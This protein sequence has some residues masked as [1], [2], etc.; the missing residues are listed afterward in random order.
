M[1]ELRRLALAAAA[2]IPLSLVSVGIASA[3]SYGGPGTAGSSETSAT[4][5]GIGGAGT[6]HSNSGYDHHGNRWT[7]ENAVLA[8]PMG[9]A[10]LHHE[11]SDWN[12][13]HDWN[14]DEKPGRPTYSHGKRPVAHTDNDGSS[15]TRHPATTLPVRESRPVRDHHPVRDNHH[16]IYAESTKTADEDGATSS[17][18]LSHAGDNHAVYEADDLSAGP[19]G[20]ESEGVKAVAKPEYTGYHKWYTAADEDGAVTHEVS[21]IAA[22]T[23]WDGDHDTYD[24]R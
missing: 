9:A 7:E 6:I 11:E 15:A 3:D 13:N 5:A 19:D 20:A 14:V 18:V 21:A 16:V 4:Y 24:R 12:T 1:T 22:V 10:V 23:D 8:G 2:V 17:H